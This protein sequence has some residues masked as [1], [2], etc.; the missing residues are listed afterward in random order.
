MQLY[1]KRH[2]LATAMVVFYKA[3]LKAITVYNIQLTLCCTMYTVYCSKYTV[4]C[5]L[6]T[7]LCSL[8]TVL[9]T[10]FTLP[11][12]LYTVLWTLRRQSDPDAAKPECQEFREL[13]QMFPSVQ[14]LVS[15]EK[16]IVQCTV[17]LSVQYSVQYSFQLSVQY[18]VQYSVQFSVQYSSVSNTN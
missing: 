7:V 1:L 15:S 8:Y 17:Q 9:C 6:F 14:C 10:L 3:L 12:S 16:C 4:H 2:I 13:P 11:S 18:S 5:T